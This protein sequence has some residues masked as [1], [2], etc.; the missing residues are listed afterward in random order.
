MRALSSKV[1]LASVLVLANGCMTVPPRYRA[2]LQIYRPALDAASVA[3]FQ[4]NEFF[5]TGAHS[6]ALIAPQLGIYAAGGGVE[7]EYR[8]VSDASLIRWF[9]EDT[10]CIR[11]LDENE[12]TP[13]RLE[14]QSWADYHY[15]LA[16]TLV[17]ILE[18]LTLTIY[19]GFPIPH[20]AEGTATVRI[21]RDDEF[22]ESVTASARLNF[23]TTLYSKNSDQPKSVA[24][25]RGM[26]LRDVADQV[27]A[28]LCGSP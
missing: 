3:G 23:V 25:A 5:P 27:A 13:L 28:R 18:T 9:L 12:N 11:K 22:S 24:L 16:G 8:T 21:Y 7:G 15:G 6:A 20:Y 17:A 1:V 26:A 4:R 10:K 14:G 19:F 2:P